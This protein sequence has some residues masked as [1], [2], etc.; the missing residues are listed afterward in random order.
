MLRCQFLT[1]CLSLYINS[2]TET[3]AFSDSKKIL[4]YTILIKTSSIIYLCPVRK[5][6]TSEKNCQKS[7]TMFSYKI[8]I[9]MV[10]FKNRKDTP[11][12]RR[13]NQ[14]SFSYI[15]MHSGFQNVSNL[16]VVKLGIFYMKNNLKMQLR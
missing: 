13:Q 2:S 3:S 8:L 10:N 5:N 12:K 11:K 4:K 1:Y 7:Q 6:K 9:Y 14:I 15:H 16:N